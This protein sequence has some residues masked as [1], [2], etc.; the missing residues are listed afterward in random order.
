LEPIKS[1]EYNLLDAAS[2][3]KIEFKHF[4]QNLYVLEYIFDPKGKRLKNFEFLGKIFQT[5]TK[6][7]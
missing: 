7:G 5:Q 1:T 6:D 3:V 4:F 2:Q